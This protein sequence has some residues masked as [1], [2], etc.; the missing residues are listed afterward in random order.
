MDIEKIT[1]EDIYK[2]SVKQIEKSCSSKESFVYKVRVHGYTTMISGTISSY[3]ESEDS[4]HFAVDGIM[5]KME[6]KDR[7]LDIS[8]DNDFFQ[9][10][11]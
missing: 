9:T 1:I 2:K 7:M 5:Y 11:L 3:S 4:I 10:T 8:I 6:Y